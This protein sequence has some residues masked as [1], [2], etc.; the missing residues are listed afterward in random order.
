MEF[1]DTR[2]LPTR[3]I[4][5]K[6]TLFVRLMFF[7]VIIQ[8]AALIIIGVFF[9]HQVSTEILSHHIRALESENHNVTNKLQNELKAMVSSAYAFALNNSINTS[10]ITAMANPDTGSEIKLNSILSDTL[11]DMIFQSNKFIKTALFILEGKIYYPTITSASNRV[12]IDRLKYLL[13]ESDGYLTFHP[14]QDNPISHSGES[15]IPI[16]FNLKFGRFTAQLIF[17][18]DYQHIHETLED[19]TDTSGLLIV[20]NAGRTVFCENPLLENNLDILSQEREFSPGV[21]LST[22]KNT[23]Y[24]RTADPIPSSGWTSYLFI[25]E[26]KVL[27]QF[28]FLTNILIFVF[29]IVFFLESML[30]YL[31]YRRLTYPLNNLA[32]I[33]S[34]PID[35][36]GSTVYRKFEYSRDDEIGVL[37]K[38][39]NE[40]IET[41]DQLVMNLNGTIEDLEIKSEQVVWEQEQSRMAE[42]KALQAQINPHFLYNTL[43]SIS[44][45]AIE[46]HADSAAKLAKGLASYYE[47]S[48]SKGLSSIPLS[49]EIEHLER[50]LEIQ[51]T[52]YHDILSYSISIPDEVMGVSIPKITLQPLAENALYHGLKPLKKRGIIKIQ[53]LSSNTDDLIISVRNNGVKMSSDQLSRINATLASGLFDMESGYGIYN[54]NSRLK[55]MFGASYGLAYYEADGFTCVD[56]RIPRK[57]VNHVHDTHSSR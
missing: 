46:Q 30:Y 27:K 24:L 25:E 52:R 45:L 29:I 5:R 34:R 49:Q 12:S 15:I 22:T 31:L 23:T 33:M 1:T 2:T 13:E 7:S 36:A 3:Q 55:L 10:I 44:W 6:K 56:V 48:L 28:Y 4:F 9:Y 40:M 26:R 32:Q 54:V 11:E 14:K 37:S 17:F 8:A 21:F 39:Y 18:I 16:V 51:S 50:Y 20:D 53:A 43:N 38:T 57:G 19:I 42:I 35:R 41:I 47:I